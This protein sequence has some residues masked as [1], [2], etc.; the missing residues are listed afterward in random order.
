MCPR[1]G[2]GRVQASLDS[3]ELLA[4]VDPVAPQHGSDAARGPGKIAFI[5]GRGAGSRVA[6]RVRV[7]WPQDVSGHR[8]RAVGAGANSKSDRGAVGRALIAVLDLEI[9]IGQSVVW[10]PDFIDISGRAGHG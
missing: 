10:L 9:E 7:V 1:I 5:R 8:S 3:K 2:P 6:G 4:A